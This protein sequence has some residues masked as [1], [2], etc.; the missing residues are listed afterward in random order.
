VRGL[1]GAR[2]MSFPF[3]AETPSQ[4]FDRLVFDKTLHIAA[5]GFSWFC[6]VRKSS[7]PTATVMAG[8]DRA[9]FDEMVKQ[10]CDHVASDAYEG[11][12]R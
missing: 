4:H 2:V 8:I 9:W 12:E 6:H 11:E 5:E 7:Q 10:M 3:P 1:H